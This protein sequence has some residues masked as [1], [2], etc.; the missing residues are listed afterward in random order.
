MQS[1][2]DELLTELHHRVW[3]HGHV[4][5]SATAGAADR[6]DKRSVTVRV[7]D[8]ASIADDLLATVQD[9]V[10]VYTGIGV[11]TTWVETRRK[12]SELPDTPTRNA[13]DLTV[14]VLSPS[15]TTRMAPPEDAIGMAANTAHTGQGRIAYVFYER[16]QTVTLQCDGSDVAALTFVMAHEIGHLLL[17]DGSHSDTGVMHGRWNRE[18]LRRLDVR[19]L[20]FTPLQGRQIR[21]LRGLAW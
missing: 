21:R 9:E 6:G 12:S 19:R 3:V 8:Y 4:G 20:R 1:I 7:D 16:L 13:A 17:P 14:I 18:T 10:G 11:E 15:M 5:L 2:D